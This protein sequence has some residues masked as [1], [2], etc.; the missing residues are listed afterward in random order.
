VGKARDRAVAVTEAPPAYPVLLGTG[1]DICLPERNRER[2]PCFRGWDMK[3]S[4]VQNVRDF[5][6][7]KW[8]KGRDTEERPPL[9]TGTQSWPTTEEG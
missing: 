8:S 2:S 3:P 6:Q 1:E 9:G 5:L 4:G 7:W